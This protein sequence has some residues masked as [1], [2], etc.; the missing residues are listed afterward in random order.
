MG[1]PTHKWCKCLILLDLGAIARSLKLTSYIYLIYF[2]YK[3]NRINHLQQQ[4]ETMDDKVTTFTQLEA[5]ENA[6]NQ[7]AESLTRIEAVLV[8]VKEELVKIR[9]G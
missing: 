8:Q 2:L 1:T 3:Y 4:E 5:V 6:L 7:I 9:E